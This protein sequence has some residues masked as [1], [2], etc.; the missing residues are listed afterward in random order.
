MAASSR[1]QKYTQLEHILARPDT[2]VGSLERDIERQWVLNADKTGMVLKTIEHV[3]GLFKIY[4]E[5]LVNAIDQAATDPTLDSIR[6]TIDD[7][8]VTVVNTGAGIPI[9]IHDKERMY[10][11]EMIFGELLTSSNYD[12]SVK[13][14]VGGRNG[15]GAKLANVFSSEF[16]LEVVDVGSQQKLSMTWT[17]NMRSKTKPVVSKK[18]CTKGYVKISFRPD[19]AKFGMAGLDADTLAL[20]EKRVYDACACTPS[21]VSVYYNGKKLG[22]KNFEK[23]VDLYIGNRKDTVR[24]HESGRRWDV[25]VCH[26]SEGYRQVSFVNGIN[27]SMGGTHV[28]HVVRKVVAKVMEKILAK[29]P[30]SQVKST[31]V[32]EHMFVF[33]K[34][35][36]ENPS[37][38]SQTKT[39]CTLKPQS[40]GSSFECS[41]DFTKRLL[42]LGILDDALALARHKEMRELSKTDGKKRSTIKGIP[43]LDDANFAG[44]SR[45]EQC[46]L[47]LTEGDSAKAFA[48]SGLS[49]VGRDYYGIFP[50][51]GKML[52]VREA[53]AKQLVDNAEINALKQ[54]LGLQQG[55]EYTSL[56]ELR[57]GKID[58]LTDADVDGSHI[59]GLVINFF[60]TFWPSLLRFPTFVQATVTPV[61][62]VSKRGEE[63]CFYTVND[64]NRWKELQ[65]CKGSSYH[66]KYYKGLGTS[67]SA[68]AK[69]YFRNKAQ[70]TVHYVEHTDATP[71]ILLAFKKEHA[72]GRKQWILDGIRDQQ[73]LEY[74]GNDQQIDF[75]D[76]INRDLIQFSIA[77]VERSI[78]SAIDGLKPSQRKV[79]YACR[80]R[81]NTEIKVS[82]LAGYA[83]TETAYHHG[84]QSMT[85]TIVGLAQDFVGS[86]NMNLLE[87]KGQFGTRLMGGKDSAS[88]RYI[89]TM[90]SGNCQ[91][92]I[93][94][95]DD[96]LL[97]YLHDDGMRVEPK[98]YV[99]TLPLV[100]IN[101]AEGIGTG[102]S[103]SVP[104]YS[105]ADVS[106]NIRRHLRG[107][108][109][110]ELTPHYRGFT[111]T[112]AQA[113]TPGQFVATGVYRVTGS[114]LEITELPVGR[115]TQDYKEFL[116]SL[117]DSKISSYEN[118]STEDRV[119]FVVR[120]D[121]RQLARCDVVKDFK[122]STSISTRNMHLFDRDGHIKKY[123]S[124]LDIIREF[125]D[126]RMHYYRARKDHIVG[127][128]G[129]SLKVLQNRVRFV[130]MVADDELVI[131]KKR[132]DAIVKEL[133]ALKFDT[134]DGVYDYLLN[135]KLY[136]LTHENIADL[137]AQQ[138]AVAKE[139]SDAKGTAPVDMWL[140]ELQ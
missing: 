114:K 58:I 85:S 100:L 92:L 79:V 55:R 67:T 81:R 19:F 94:P 48:V 108:D 83:S 50:L 75:A 56:S 97:E 99:P 91:R 46:T 113:S 82:Q 41:E 95:A 70:N 16:H 8:V 34:A 88:P 102:Y 4:D 72:D 20:F 124:P 137:R 28:D 78:P 52:N 14:T 53:T 121:A 69:E 17:D 71:P 132:K 112:I 38:S 80:K 47:I 126:V 43:K 118:H 27:T 125:V 74:T 93:K 54:I 136:T 24:I 33:V 23:Y 129:S 31:F 120:M 90:L 30:N 101:G 84:E 103:C 110:R 131:F 42:K 76:F 2:Y 64:Y 116:D 36:L 10:I 86:N 13:R 139:L 32:K 122:L 60:H 104:C 107:E 25:A 65:P 6:V 128:L 68:E 39:E 51:R 62:K 123:A 5:I 111:G 45:S 11:P 1:Y 117:V 40:F 37:F 135:M 87:P 35:T 133:G 3:P 140:S 49:V 98:Y 18:S 138:S 22:Y 63:H 89:F 106:D 26:S 59:K 7:D 127:Q 96:P 66:V 57:Y 105:P 44:T 9:E 29:N 61:L 21:R 115:W 77:D 134:V 12:D 73:T 15:Y 119:R 109:M 130:Q